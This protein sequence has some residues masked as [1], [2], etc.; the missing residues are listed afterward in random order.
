M[1]IFITIVH[2]YLSCLHVFLTY[3]LI[4]AFCPQLRKSPKIATIWFFQA[5]KAIKYSPKFIETILHTYVNTSD[6]CACV[7]VMI[8][9]LSNLSIDL[10]ILSTIEKIPKNSHYMIF[11][12]QQSEYVVTKSIHK[13]S[14]THMWILLTIVHVYL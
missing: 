5:S 2:V 13:P 4:Y 12:G 10:R 8:G 3:L 9:C 7:F 14:Y 11:P 1:A 6:H